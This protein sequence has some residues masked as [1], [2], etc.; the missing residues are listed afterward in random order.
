MWVAS[1]DHYSALAWQSVA[2]PIRRHF[3]HQQQQQLQHARWQ[4]VSLFPPRTRRFAPSFTT[5][6]TT[7]LKDAAAHFPGNSPDEDSAER[8]EDA[9][10]AAS[11]GPPASSSSSPGAYYAARTTGGS[12]SAANPNKSTSSSSS[13]SLLRTIDEWGLGLKPKAVHANAKGTLS[14][15]RRGRFRYTL[16]S[17]ALWTLFI[18]Y[19]AYRGFFVIAPAVFRATFQKLQTVVD[20]APFD[21]QYF[22]LSS[23]LSSS[24]GDVRN[25]TKAPW[26]TRL[27]VSV[28]AAIVTV[29]YLLGGALRVLRHLLQSSWSNRDVPRSL[30]AAASEQERN[31][32]KLLRL[33]TTRHN[34]NKDDDAP[35]TGVN[36]QSPGLAP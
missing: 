29:S 34:K 5:T 28:L 15:T 8:K 19:R 24:R 13:S 36:G 7:P 12:S 17:C 21:D 31:E 30:Q 32:A 22:S 26:R 4:R 11:R 1:S 9:A 10:D 3:Q 14:E 35:N 20:D 2:P 16:Q 6:T 33:A 27:T 25:K 18:V 23:S